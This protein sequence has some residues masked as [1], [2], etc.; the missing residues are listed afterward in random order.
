MFFCIFCSFVLLKDVRM[1]GVVS[2]ALLFLS[3]VIAAQYKI[4][5]LDYLLLFILSYFVFLIG[6]VLIKIIFR[7]SVSL[8]I[9][10][11]VSENKFKKSEVEHLICHRYPDL[12]NLHLT[13]CTND[14]IRPTTLGLCLNQIYK[15]S[16]KILLV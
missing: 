16:K 13:V 7:R 11:M 5:E 9:I 2:F 14:K 4:F 3:T 6:L 15:L 10:K 12:L 8:T 1:F